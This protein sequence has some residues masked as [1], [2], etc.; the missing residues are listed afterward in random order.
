MRIGG[1]DFPE[2]LLNALRDGRLVVFAGAGVSMGP[3]ANLPGFRELARQIA[4]GTGFYIG[5]FE[6][7]DQFLGRLKD[8]GPD[9]H[10]IAAQ[11][12]Q[13]N[14]PKPTELH[15]HL[16]RLYRRAKD[17]RIVTT[18]FDQL[19]EEAAASTKPTVFNA[20]VLPLGQRF[21]GIVHI[22]G[23][24][25]QPEEMVL[26]D[27]DFGRAYLTE[28]DGWARRFLVDFFANNTVLF[29][30][31][32]H[33]DTIMT[34]LTPSLPRDDTTRRYALIGEENDDLG[35][36]LALGVQPITFRQGHPDYYGGLDK[37][38]G[39]LADHIRRGILDW[40]REI[41]A[42]ASVPPPIDE[43]SAGIIE[44][45]LSTPE[46]TQFF[47]RAAESPDWIDWLDRRHHL[48]TLFTDGKLTE[49]EVMLAS[50][51]SRRFALAHDGA[52]FRTIESH[53]SRLNPEF[54][55][56]L[57]WQMQDSIPKSPDAAAMTRWVLFLASVTPANGDDIALS[58]I[59]EASDSVGAM[60]ALLRAYE[61][62][63]GFSEPRAASPRRTQLR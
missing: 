59:A 48:A 4:E 23:S 16:L 13:R 25:N 43:E 57:S 8:T 52:L 30:G 29:V 61:A 53:R 47:T 26:T 49:Q 22:H 55:K 58:W 18:N 37:A 42:I 28:S 46:A 10:Q 33:S 9:V 41:T 24:V 2:P 50:W 20:P 3:P 14:N 56:L 1:V 60:D 62:M 7:E 44:Y 17:T 5:E 15:R 35:R 11:R 54:W 45:A 32:S 38:V 36:W 21:Q 27:R 19:F 51:L 6:A 12:L 63:T 31:Y 39:S 40:Q 34:Y